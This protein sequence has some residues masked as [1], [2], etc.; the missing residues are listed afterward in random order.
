MQQSK[1][2]HSERSSPI[3]TDSQE[4]NN[5]TSKN[6]LSIIMVTDFCHLYHCYKYLN[7]IFHRTC[8]QAAIKICSSPVERKSQEDNHLTG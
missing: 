1:L 5:L 7:S 3:K 8:Q 6:D 2:A 4:N